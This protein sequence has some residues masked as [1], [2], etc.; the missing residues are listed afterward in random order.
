MRCLAGGHEDGINEFMIV[1]VSLL[2]TCEDF[3]EVVN[4]S[5]DPLYFAFYG[6][7]DNEYGA[8]DAASSGDVEV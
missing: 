8:Y 6:A 7:L 1:R 4:R 3:T 2:G 5:L